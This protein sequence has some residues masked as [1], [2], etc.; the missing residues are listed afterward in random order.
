MSLETRPVESVRGMLDLDAQQAHAQAQLQQSLLAA[1]QL[2]SYTPIDVPLVEQADLYMRKSG[3]DIISKMYTFEDFGGRRLA[4]RP[5]FTASVVRYYLSNDQNAPIPLRYAYAGPVF[6]YEKPQRGRYRQF[7]MAGVELLG[8]DGP[9][10][11]AEVI[12]LAC[13]TLERLGV[14]QYRLVL[15]HV[16]ILLELL[17]S[18]GLSTRLKHFLL[19][20]MEDV[21]RPGRG[22][23]YVRKRLEEIHPA[24]HAGTPAIVDAPGAEAQ[25]QATLRAS[26]QEMGIELHGSRTEEAILS[27]MFRKQRTSDEDERVERAFAFIQGLHGL[28][29]AP[30]EVLERA[31]VFLEKY[32]L[33]DEPLSRLAEVVAALTAYGIEESHVQVQLA[34]G[35]G[36]HYYTDVVFELYDDSGRSQL[37]GGGRYNELVQSLGGRKSVPAVGF[38]IGLERLRLALE[39]QGTALP[40]AP[41]VQVLVAAA[42]PAAA[43]VGMQAAQR[44]R[45]HGIRTEYDLRQR[46]ARTRVAYANRKSIPYLLLVEDGEGSLNLRNMADG[47]TQSLSLSEVVQNIH[48]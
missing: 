46:N 27:R 40:A 38:A 11:D 30:G 8:S 4:L 7:S 19:D 1:F 2:A 35:R 18:L 5:E 12:A 6:R 26:L 43:R 21:G 41:R 13:W 22:L 20:S 32:G 47:T 3:A 44:L 39:Q 10:A 34:L 45:E 37:C 14:K 48:G 24:R 17:G 28:T 23:A 42:T 36:L 29:G 15:G 9:S 33:G 31:R 16:G 25:A